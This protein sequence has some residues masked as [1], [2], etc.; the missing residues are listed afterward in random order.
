M[1]NDCSFQT[2]ES[3]RFWQ[4]AMTQRSE[5]LVASQVMCNKVP[6]GVRGFITSIALICSLGLSACSWPWP[7]ATEDTTGLGRSEIARI[8]KNICCAPPGWLIREKIQISLGEASKDHSA[9]AAA[10]SIGFACDASPSKICRYAGEMKYQVHG[11]PKENI[12]AEK[13]HIVSYSI[14]LPNYDDVNDIRAERKTTVV[15]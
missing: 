7:S 5:D 13:I 10:E 6:I 14:V 2:D 1:V 15:P 3:K 11:V 9:R 8:L 12:D 4:G